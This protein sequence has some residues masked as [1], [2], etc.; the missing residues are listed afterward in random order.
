MRRQDPVDE[1]CPAPGQ[2]QDED[3][4]RPNGAGRRGLRHPLRIEGVHDQ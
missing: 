1:G 3:R 4:T 2:A